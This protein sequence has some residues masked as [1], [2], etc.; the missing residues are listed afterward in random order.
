[1]WVERQ[2]YKDEGDAAYVDGL[3]S[4]STASFFTQL[5]ALQ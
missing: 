3:D 2:I 4:K 1:M 5:K